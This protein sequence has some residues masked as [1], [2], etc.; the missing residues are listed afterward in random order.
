MRYSISSAGLDDGRIT[1]NK[2]TYS[3]FQNTIII[4]TSNIGSHLIQERIPEMPSTLILR[5]LE[6]TRDE[7]M[8]LFKKTIGLNF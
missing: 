8:D 5:V 2:S 1:D 6:Q 3:Q 4:M 7:V